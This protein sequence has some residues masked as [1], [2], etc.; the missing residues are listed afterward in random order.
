MKAALYLDAGNVI[1]DEVPDPVIVEPTD[2]VVQIVRSC[3]CGSDLWAYRDTFK[4]AE[5]SRLGH[6]FIGVVTEIGSA[7]ST[8]KPGDLVIAPFSYGDGTCP[9]C[10]EGLYT[11]ARTGGRS[12]PPATTGARAR[13]PGC[14]MPTPTWSP[15]RA[16]SRPSTTASC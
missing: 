8:I 9:A 12:A 16:G 6:E 7:V 10:A 11:R 3:V 13:Q 1:V 14:P 15:C 4:R 5:R 2:A